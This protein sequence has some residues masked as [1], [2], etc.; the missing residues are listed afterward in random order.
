M[1]AS[2]R[3][4]AKDYAAHDRWLVNL[5][6]VITSNRLDDLWENQ[7]VPTLEAVQRQFT[8]ETSDK[9][10]E[11]FAIAMKHWQTE[12]T[13]LYFLVKDSIIISGDWETLDRETIK[14][15]FTN[16]RLR[17]GLAFIAWVNSFYDH[18]SEDGQIALNAEFKRIMLVKP[19]GAGGNLASMRKRWLDGFSVWKKLDG[20]DESDRVKLE[21]YF[22]AMIASMPSAPIEHPLV[23]T[24]MWLSEKLHERSPMF[25]TVEE[26]INGTI[27]FAGALGIK[28]MSNESG[29]QIT[30]VID[31]SSGEKKYTK[32]DNNCKF[33]S[34]WCCNNKKGTKL[35]CVMF[36][37]DLDMRC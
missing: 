21:T 17:D 33:C 31:P 36:N 24:R 35:G 18:T 28:P 34:T 5:Q 3:L 16:G 32:E 9:Q 10:Q 12:N 23:R 20:N 22:K 6:D 11:L 19:D 37:P 8:K 14:N 15:R 30:P 13:Q 7:Q 2:L 1:E 4:R 29:K 25:S 27:R 26:A